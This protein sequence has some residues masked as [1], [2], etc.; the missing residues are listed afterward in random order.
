MVDATIIFE[1]NVKKMIAEAKDV[2]YAQFLTQLLYRYR[3]NQMTKEQVMAEI[4]RTYPLYLQR[5]G[6]AVVQQTQ[7]QQKQPVEKKNM[8]FTV[9]AGVLGVIGALFILIAFVMLGITYM[10]SFVKGM[11]LY[12]IAAVVLLTSELAVAKKMPYFSTVLTGIGISGLFLTTIINMTYLE[13]FGPLVGGIIC[14]GVFA[15]ALFLGK[16]KESGVLHLIN[17]IGCYLCVFPIWGAVSYEWRGYSFINLYFILI[18]VIIFA[19]N[20]FSVLMYGK[21]NNSVIHILHQCVNAVLT[22][23][24]AINALISDVELFGVFVYVS[25]ALLMLGVNLKMYLRD[26]K[27][28]DYK[29]KFI[30]AYITY[31]VTSVLLLVLVVILCLLSEYDIWLHIS[32]GIFVLTEIVLFIMFGKNWLKWVAYESACFTILAI[33]GL[34]AGRENYSYE[35][36]ILVTIAIFAITK[37]LAR[38]NLIHAGDIVITLIMAGWTLFSFAQDSLLYALVLFITFVVGLFIEKNW[39]SLYEELLLVLLCGFVLINFLNELTPVILVCIITAGFFIFNNIPFFRDNYIKVYNYINLGI[40]CIIY[41]VAPFV[42][43]PVAMFILLF[44]CCGFMIFAF[45]EKYGM[46][47]RIKS[48]LLVL[49]LSY[50]VFTGDLQPS[51]IKS[52]LLMVIAVT[53]VVAGF[54]RKEKKLRITGLVLSLVVCGKLLLYDFQGAANLEKIIL[55]L[56]VGVIVLAISGVYI[57][58]EKKMM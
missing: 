33:Y 43:S 41:L 47:F 39:K 26:S 42:V 3:Q 6:Q 23:A 12:V 9:G 49:L 46:N 53:A 19:I 11:L 2:R 56:T 44:L 8:E 51:V 45:D 36:A 21:K 55:F 17:F 13:N 48:I 14:V 52:I 54:V 7:I 20:F 15:I 1:N 31:I 37:I 35:L 29:E 27:K 50:M 40:L 24:F 5:T 32:V 18:V 57:A 10:N 4:N 22:I 38:C 30:G 34:M 25:V 58:L 28:D 16:K